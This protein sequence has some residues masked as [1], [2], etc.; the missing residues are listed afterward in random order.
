MKLIPSSLFPTLHSSECWFVFFTILSRKTIE[1]SF[2]IISQ[3]FLYSLWAAVLQH[4]TSNSSVLQIILVMG[5]DRLRLFQVSSARCFKV[6]KYKLCW[7]QQLKHDTSL[8]MHRINTITKIQLSV[9][10]LYIGFYFFPHWI[11]SLYKKNI[12]ILQVSVSSAYSWTHS[13]NGTV[14]LTADGRDSLEMTLGGRA[15]GSRY[16]LQWL[17]LQGCFS[18][19]KGGPSEHLR[20]TSSAH[21]GLSEAEIF[22]VGH[23]GQ[24]RGRKLAIWKPFLRRTDEQQLRLCRDFAGSVPPEQPCL[25]PCLTL[26]R[27]MSRTRLLLSSLLIWIIP[28]HHGPLNL[29]VVH[30]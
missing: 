8:Y 2:C 18:L 27:A 19:G 9:L 28:R 3:K 15:M 30:S 11:L 20:A 1:P 25:T 10:H 16:C 12:G 4:G 29:V 22:S 7:F 13:S 23:S 5:N 17:V 26:L 6:L 21:E 14:H 24:V